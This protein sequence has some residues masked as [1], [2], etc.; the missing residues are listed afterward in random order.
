MLGN[1]AKVVKSSKLVL[2]QISNSI[3]Y[4]VVAHK[5]IV[6]LC[7]QEIE[8]VSCFRDMS[9]KYSE[10]LNLEILKNAN[11]INRSM[12]SV[13]K[14]GYTKFIRERMVYKEMNEPCFWMSVAELVNKK[15]IV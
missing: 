14:G 15:M 3:A 4:G 7:N 13:E 1:T 6:L 2:S 11:E 8:K 5:S 9:F 12:L 10:Q